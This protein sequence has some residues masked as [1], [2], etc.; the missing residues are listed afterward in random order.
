[1][2]LVDQLRFGPFST[3]YHR[4][5]V[6]AT[7]KEQ[8]E[9]FL[10]HN[11]ILQLDS[12]LREFDG[13]LTATFDNEKNCGHTSLVRDIFTLECIAIC[14]DG[15]SDVNSDI[16][17]D[18]VHGAFTPRTG[19][20]NFFYVWTPTRKRTRE[21]E[22]SAIQRVVDD[23]MRGEAS[24]FECPIC[25]GEITAVNNPEIFD[26]RCKRRRCFVYNFHKDECGRL[27]HGHFFTTHPM[28]RTEQ[29]GEQ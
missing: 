7:F 11:L 10:Q 25:G 17:Y 24:D 22:L 8:L 20:D 21:S 12:P 14:D 9:L 4:E 1:M 27:A 23:I 5:S 6:N 19:F 28:K 13:T 29:C 2:K 3:S 18:P 26:A 16:V 15:M